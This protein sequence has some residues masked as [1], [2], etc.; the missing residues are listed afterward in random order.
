MGE[1]VVFLSQ[2][3]YQALPDDCPHLHPGAACAK[4]VVHRDFRVEIGILAQA[5]CQH[6]FSAEDLVAA[7]LAFIW[8]TL[9][10]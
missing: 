5:Q 6:L 1:W 3:P 9:I 2:I 7:G 4:R 8:G 10:A